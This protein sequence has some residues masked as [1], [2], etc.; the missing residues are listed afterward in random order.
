MGESLSIISLNKA[1]PRMNSLIYRLIIKR[2]SSSATYPT[3]KLCDAEVFYYPS[4][5]AAE[6]KIREFEW[7]CDLYCFIIEAC[8]FGK[9]VHDKAYHRWV[10]D[11]E[12]NF[13]SE[14]LCS[15]F[16]DP[17]THEQDEWFPGRLPEQCRFKPGDYVEVVCNDTVTLGIV[18]ECPPTPEDVADKGLRCSRYD[19]P[20]DGK[21]EYEEDAYMTLHG[22]VDLHKYLQHKESLEFA[23]AT[24]VLPASLPI[25]EIMKEQLKHLLVT[26]HDEI[27]YWMGDECTIGPKSTGLEKCVAV[28]SKYCSAEPVIY[29]LT[30]C[31]GALTV[32][33]EKEPK[34]IR[35]YMTF[36]TAEEFAKVKE[37][38]KLN[39]EVLMSNWND[40]DSGA[41]C[42]NVKRV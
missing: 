18:M 32:S 38:I 23:Y 31:N 24:N 2:R 11:N 19:K 20:F 39:Y 22:R 5:E 9:D 42:R 33:V 7:E 29:Y 21:A 37:W 36:V 3:F 28:R 26:V 41:L 4:K 6:A 1:K 27:E 40:P 8:P 35:G 15:E 25:P 30:P 13:I 14:T 16:D 34:R 10:Y 12:G 17:N